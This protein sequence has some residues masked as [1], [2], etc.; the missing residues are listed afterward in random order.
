MIQYRPSYSSIYYRQGLSYKLHAVRLRE[1]LFLEAN[2]RR[3]LRLRDW[4]MILHAGSPHE[5]DTNLMDFDLFTVPCFYPSRGA[6]V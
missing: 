6:N 2:H 1:A 5:G 4:S 3:R